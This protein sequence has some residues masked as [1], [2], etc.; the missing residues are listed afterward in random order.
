MTTHFQKNEDVIE[1]ITVLGHLLLQL[2][3][4][5]ELDEWMAASFVLLLEAGKANPD[6][7]FV[8]SSFSAQMHKSKWI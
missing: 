2:R 5:S 1:L 4:F 6:S 7:A 8:R 3:L